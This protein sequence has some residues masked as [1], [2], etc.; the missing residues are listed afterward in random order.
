MPLLP[1][2][3]V[4]NIDP[5]HAERLIMQELDRRDIPYVIEVIFERCINPQTGIHLRFDFYLPLDNSLV[6]YDGVDAHST[7]EAK[8]RDKI[9][10]KFAKDNSIKLTRISGLGNIQ[11]WA[12]KRFGAIRDNIINDGSPIATLPKYNN[13]MRI[14]DELSKVKELHHSDPRKARLH[15]VKVIKQ[16]QSTKFKSAFKL[17]LSKLGIKLI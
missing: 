15:A 2:E 14:S 13:W 6:E 12:F 4:P 3:C 11:R 17:E 5:S 1:Y 10:T 9:K 16:N 7:V 8:L